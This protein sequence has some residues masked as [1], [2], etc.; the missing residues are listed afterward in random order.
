MS[1]LPASYIWGN[2]VVIVNAD[3]SIDVQPGDSLSAYSAAIYGN[4]D[5]IG[6][7]T[8]RHREPIINKNM[9]TAFTKDH[10]EIKDKTIP[11]GKTYKDEF[12]KLYSKV[13]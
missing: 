5:H 12:E 9:I 10:I 2:R 1:F 6:K 8:R 13:L 4:F 11:I 7:F 3:R